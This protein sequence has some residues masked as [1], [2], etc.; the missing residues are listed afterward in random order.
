MALV[1]NHVLVTY[2]NTNHL[3]NAIRIISK[4]NKW[5]FPA[6]DDREGWAEAFKLSKQYAD[7]KTTEAAPAEAEKPF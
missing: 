4:N 1:N 2:D 5:N 3:R 7:S 6:P